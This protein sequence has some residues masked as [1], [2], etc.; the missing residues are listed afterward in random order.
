[1]TNNKDQQGRPQDGMQRHEDMPRKPMP[2]ERPDPTRERSPG[3][4]GQG[5]PQ[6]PR[7]PGDGQQQGGQHSNPRPGQQGQDGGA[8]GQQGGAGERQ[9]QPNV[10][11]DPRTDLSRENPYKS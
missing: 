3:Q 8:G 10:A 9:K 5:T 6:T 4:Q 2:N 7:G 11:D 1:M